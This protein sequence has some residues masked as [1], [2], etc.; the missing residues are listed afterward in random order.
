MVIL[1]TKWYELAY[2]LLVISRNIHGSSL[3]PYLSTLHDNDLTIALMKAQWLERRAEQ[4][5]I[6]KHLKWIHIEKELYN[7]IGS[8]AGWRLHAA[9]VNVGVA[10]AVQHLSGV[11]GRVV[12]CMKLDALDDSDISASTTSDV[13]PETE[14]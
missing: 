1:I 11:M 14:T 5:L 9:D 6:N 13:G 3:P 12:G 4:R 8:Q 2:K 7:H 10:Y